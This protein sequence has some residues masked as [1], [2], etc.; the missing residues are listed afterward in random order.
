VLSSDEAGS[1]ETHPHAAAMARRHGLHRLVLRALVGLIH[2]YRL[3]LSPFIGNQCRFYPSCS[4]YAEQALL[5]HGLARGAWLA[6]RRLSRCHPFN[7]GGPDPV[8]PVRRSP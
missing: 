2:L 7:P 6:I 1:T 4:R 3:T 5:D 8:P